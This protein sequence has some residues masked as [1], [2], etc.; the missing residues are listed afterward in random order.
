MGY[1]KVF[2]V[3]EMPLR[4]FLRRGGDR[5]T[6]AR[7]VGKQVLGL[8]VPLSHRPGASAAPP[9]RPFFRDPHTFRAS[10]TFHSSATGLLLWTGTQLNPVQRDEFVRLE[11]A[12]RESGTDGVIRSVI[13]D[14][15]RYRAITQGRAQ[16]DN[17]L[18]VG[19][20]IMA[21][22]WYVYE[23]YTR[24]FAGRVEADWPT[25]AVG[26]AVLEVML[27]NWSRD[28]EVQ[29]A[30]HMHPIRRVCS[31]VGSPTTLFVWHNNCLRPLSAFMGADQDGVDQAVLQQELA[32]IRRAMSE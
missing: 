23:D 8:S 25:V 13:D 2:S 14:Q 17:A 31:F 15:H 18:A 21:S 5:K 6:L 28:C 24:Q 22:V 32:D 10:A 3:R 11:S 4:H 7:E 27:S 29:G 16:W 19:R 9:A 30:N 26:E 1:A 20:D 12:C